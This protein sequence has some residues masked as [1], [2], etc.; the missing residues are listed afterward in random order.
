MLDIWQ[1]IDS[2][3]VAQIVAFQKERC[4]EDI[5]A[6]KVTAA[7]SSVCPFPGYR[8]IRLTYSAQR[9]HVRRASGDEHRYELV[10]GTI[11][12]LLVKIGTVPDQID[13]IPLNP[14]AQTLYAIN[15][16]LGLRLTLDS[17][18]SYLV[19]FGLVIEA[20]EGSFY[21]VTNLNHIRTIREHLPEASRTTLDGM[22]GGAFEVGEEGRLALR[23]GQKSYPL[24]GKAFTLTLLAIYSGGAYKA[25]VRVSESGVPTMD[26]D[27][28][29][30]IIGLDERLP[31]MKRHSL[32]FS[33][34]IAVAI[35][36]TKAALQSKIKLTTTILTFERVA[37]VLLL[38]A[39]FMSMAI[40]FYAG[41]D[42]MTVHQYYEVL[43][44]LRLLSYANLAVSAALMFGLLTRYV[45][46]E[47]GALTEK[48][49]PNQ[50][51]QFFFSATELL[52]AQRAKM[53]LIPFV[54][55]AAFEFMAGAFLAM[56]MFIYGVSNILDVP[57]VSSGMNFVEAFIFVILSVPFVGRG[58]AWVL[59]IKSAV[60]LY[61]VHNSPILGFVSSTFISTITLGYLLRMFRMSE[62]SG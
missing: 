44:S 51:S 48:W 31:I 61:G 4:F 30:T 18:L 2:G 1:P 34:P 7:E 12:Y 55:I 19:F 36:R 25:D 22:I 29:T 56:N 17:V 11:S 47:I 9:V 52:K 24:L 21:F 15:K 45:V 13:V 20:D 60:G 32:E 53:G 42:N 8:F 35:G 49:V 37:S 39:Y 26:E 28:P 14:D 50:L 23:I 6:S 57:S 40:A 16:Q 43:K 54:F 5:D 10:D 27:E 38:P 58:L 41:L 33:A 62:R 46:M 59:N 3:L